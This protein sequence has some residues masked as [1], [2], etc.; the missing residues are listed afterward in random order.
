MTNA[1]AM[2]LAWQAKYEPFGNT[3][4]V[5]ASP[6]N[7]MRLPGQWF[8]IEDGLAYNWHRTYDPS[9]GRYSQADPLG[10]VDGP[11][12]YGYARQ[13][14]VMRVD[15]WGLDTTI[16]IWNGGLGGQHAG[17]HISNP[18]SGNG[19]IYDPGGGFDDPEMGSGRLHVGSDVPPISRHMQPNSSGSCDCETYTFPTTPEEEAQIIENAMNNGDPGP[20]FCA[21]GLQNAIAGVGPFSNIPA[22][23]W[24]SPNALGKRL[25]RTPLD[26]R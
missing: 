2:T 10:F 17:L 19:A 9:L 4:L 5:T 16:I 7:N 1:T 21:S 20:F 23:N 18:H 14:P 8:Q 6:V 12:V 26:R 15:P 13:S 22:T 11:S 3:V 25:K 24:T